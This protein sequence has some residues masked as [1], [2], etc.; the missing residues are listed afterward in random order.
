MSSD[1]VESIH[2]RLR[3]EIEKCGFSL[4]AASRAANEASPQRL[5]DVVSGR[6]RCS[7]DLVA[8][9]MAIGVDGLYVL[10]GIRASG[11]SLQL[12]ADEEVLLEGYRALDIANRK[13]LLAALLTGNTS[14]D[15]KEPAQSI[16]NQKVS[17]EGHRVAG[18]DFYTKE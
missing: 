4:A 11:N 18:R 13:K 14:S 5:K 16:V 7:A 6:Q 1:L 10:S 17:G 15:S 2:V 8:K 12:A 3:E 9:M